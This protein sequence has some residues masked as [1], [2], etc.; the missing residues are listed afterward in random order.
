MSKKKTNKN[1]GRLIFFLVLAVIMLDQ[2]TK[3]L[4]RSQ[5]DVQESLPVIQHVFN[6]TYVTNTGSAFGILR[7]FNAALIFLSFVALGLIAFYWDRLT[8]KH[9]QF[10]FALVSAGIIGNLIDRLTL[11]YV[12]DFINF[13]F[14]PAFNVAD[15]AIS[16]GI[17]CL[18][19]YSWRD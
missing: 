14:W 9:E 2:G 13:S 17:I 11:G 10:F 15:A 6:I 1:Y 4:I 19:F 16:I 5:F 3:L 7:G 18:I 12:V 8:A